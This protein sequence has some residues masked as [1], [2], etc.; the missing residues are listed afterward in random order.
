VVAFV[1]SWCRVHTSCWVK[2]SAGRMDFK[3]RCQIAK[4]KFSVMSMWGASKL[5]KVPKR[6]QKFRPCKFSAGLTSAMHSDALH[7][8][9]YKRRV[10]ELIWYLQLTLLM[11]VGNRNAVQLCNNNADNVYSRAMTLTAWESVVRFNLIDEV[12]SRESFDPVTRVFWNDIEF[13]A[14]YS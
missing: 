12:H 4:S 11:T 13:L 10:L 9:P 2:L 6:M 14:K 3:E 7:L 5:I 8:D 1:P